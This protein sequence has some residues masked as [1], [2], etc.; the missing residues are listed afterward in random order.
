MGA[1]FDLIVLTL[2]AV[3]LVAILR[4]GVPHFMGT[5]RSWGARHYTDMSGT[6]NDRK[7]DNSH[8]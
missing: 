6:D 2:I 1:V 8:T 4:Y 3:A 7:H 5:F